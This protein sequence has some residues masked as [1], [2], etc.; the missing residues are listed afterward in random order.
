VDTVFLG[1]ECVLFFIEHGARR[2]H[3]VGVTRYITVGIRYLI[4]D[5]AGCFSEASA[6]SSPPSASAWC[7]SCRACLG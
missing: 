5:N 6:W 3:I 1:C 4:R 2:V 7:P